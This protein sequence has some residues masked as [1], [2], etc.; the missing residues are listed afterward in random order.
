MEPNHPE[1]D[2]KGQNPRN[3]TRGNGKRRRSP[4]SDGRKDR[5]PRKPIEV[6]NLYTTLSNIEHEDDSKDHVM[7]RIQLE[8]ERQEVDDQ[9]NDRLRSNR[10]LHRPGIMRQIPDTDTKSKK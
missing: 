10:G 2:T 3:G 9:C 6:R 1:M 7:V 4:V 5:P 8:G